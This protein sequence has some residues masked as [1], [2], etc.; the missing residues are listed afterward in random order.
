MKIIPLAFIV[1]TAVVLTAVSTQAAYLLTI[2]E[3]DPTA[4]IVAATG[5]NATNGDAQYYYAG[6]TLRD[7]FTSEA[8]N[9]SGSWNYYPPNETLS[10]A[11]NPMTGY[12]PYDGYFFWGTDRHTVGGPFN[13]T[14]YV[15]MNLFFPQGSPMGNQFQPFIPGHPA[16]TGTN[17]FDLSSKNLPAYGTHGP[18]YVGNSFYPGLTTPAAAIGEWIVIGPVPPPPPPPNWLLT[19]AS[20]I[21]STQ[22]GFSIN[23][24]NGE[25]YA[26]QYVTNLASTNWLTLTNITLT[27][28]PVPVVDLS[29]TG[30]TRYY[31][32]VKN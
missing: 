15:D 8:G 23:G 21:S 20:R 26:V 19:S 6:V 13:Y 9:N 25:N 16:F 10:A 12:D 1:F 11:M 18:I 3:T 32:A 31:R 28:P 14:G 7:F 17:Y 27:N 29:A 2:D 22:F 4:V 24:T 30:S 5:A